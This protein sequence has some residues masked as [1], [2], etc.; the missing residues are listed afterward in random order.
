MTVSCPFTASGVDATPTTSVTVQ[1]GDIIVVDTVTDT[2]ANPVTAVACA[3]LVA[4]GFSQVGSNVS[5]ASGFVEIHNEWIGVVTTA[6]TANVTVTTAA[7]NYKPEVTVYRD[8]ALA[9]NVKWAVESQACNV[10]AAATTMTGIT[11]TSV[12]TNGVGHAY[13]SPQNASGTAGP[14]DTSTTAFTWTRG[15]DTWWNDR[16]FSPFTAA[17]ATFAPS[18]NQVAYSSAGTSTTAT[19]GQYIRRTTVFTASPSVEPGR[20]LMSG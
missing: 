12:G 11:A 2:V 7:T 13:F 1:V 20:M 4:G 8:T 3:S 15:T 18:R 19:S 14:T 17:G 5:N 16:G 9:P 10:A 6:G